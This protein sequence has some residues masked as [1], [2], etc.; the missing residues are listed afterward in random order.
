MIENLLAVVW[1]GLLIV[2]PFWLLL[3]VFTVLLFIWDAKFPGRDESD[4]ASSASVRVNE[5]DR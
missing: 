1:H 4:T 2:G 5:G 3:V